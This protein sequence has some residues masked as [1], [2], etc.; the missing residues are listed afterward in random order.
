[1]LS[2]CVATVL[3]LGGVS[4]FGQAAPTAPPSL[5]SPEQAVRG[6]AVYQNVCIE[7]HETLQYTSPDFKRKWGGRTIFALY[8]VLAN[9]MPDKNPGSLSAQE[10]IDVVGYMLKLNGV[11]PG[12]TDLP[13]VD[14]ILKKFKME[15]PPPAGGAR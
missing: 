11:A 8:D 7:C 15:F 9:T 6:E 4:A 5:Y 1:M 13:P 12:K 3:S 2:A 14:S 10:Y